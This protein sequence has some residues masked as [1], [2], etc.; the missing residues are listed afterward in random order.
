MRRVQRVLTA[1]IGLLAALSL[2]ACSS[3]S[4]GG[5]LAP[6]KV[7]GDM[8]LIEQTLAQ[9]IKGKYTLKYPTAGEYRSAYIL[10]DL[11]GSGKKEFA[12]A[13]YSVTGMDN[14]TAMH[15]N[16]MK[17][18]DGSWVMFSDV[19]ISAVGVEKVELSDL[20]GDGVKEIIVGWN[21]YSNVEKKAVVYSLSDKTLDAHTQETYT[22][23]LCGDVRG[24]GQNDLFILNHNLDKSEAVAKLLAY[25]NNA[26]RTVG[27][28]QLNGGATA[29][30]AP[31]LSKLTGGEPAVFID[32]SLTNGTQT[33]VVFYRDGKL[34]NPVREAAAGGQAAT[35]TFRSSAVACSDINGDGV[36]DIP[37]SHASGVN[38]GLAANANQINQTAW[39]SFD[40]NQLVV[41]VIAV[42]NYTDGY[43]FVL[44]KRWE[45]KVLIQHEPES[46][47]CTVL[48]Q[49]PEAAAMT[50]LVRVKTVAE[51]EWDKT[52]NGFAAYYELTRRGGSVFIAM[53]GVYTGEEA[54][55]MDE[56]RRIFHLIQ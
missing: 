52:E 22:E 55:D 32:S 29:F 11:F 46:R 36:M 33:E 42:M 4:L 5:T 10:A 47:S 13:L 26:F 31:Q 50:E 17:E 23:F 12:L 6:P 35:F 21:I 14:I 18:V 15:L 56:M 27:S 3:M 19:Q 9:N 7:G 8:Q 16:L 44:P 41:T 2:S 40:G 48:L 30:S 54:V 1:V 45:N 38:T 20:D 34:Q 24:R 28:C 51:S 25:E 53:P 49:S 37:I 43:F 39:C